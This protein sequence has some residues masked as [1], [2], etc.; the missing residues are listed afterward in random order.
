M[1]AINNF[2]SP[3]YAARVLKGDLFIMKDY[4]LLGISK[5]YWTMAITCYFVYTLYN[6][7]HK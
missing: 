3:T 5:F 4:Y 6:F 1:L 2:N 7:N